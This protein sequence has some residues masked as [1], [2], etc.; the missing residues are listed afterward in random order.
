TAPTSSMRGPAPM[1]DKSSE[2]RSGRN[3]LAAEPAAGVRH[4]VTLSIVGTD[5]TPDNGYFRAQ[6]A[7]EK[8]IEASGIPYTIIRSLP[9]RANDHS[10]RSGTG[11]DVPDQHLC[12]CWQLVRDL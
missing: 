2:E 3:L 11:W 10:C 6:V 4:H 9:P 12:R 1:P 8:M 7:Q 5:R